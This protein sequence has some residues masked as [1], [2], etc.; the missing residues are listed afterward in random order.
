MSG[1]GGSSSDGGG[2]G[3]QHASAKAAMTG[4]AAYSGSTKP[5]GPPGG[6]ATS[7]GSGRD[8]APSG[9][10]NTGGDYDDNVRDTY[11]PTT[12]IESIHGE[13]DDPGSAS[14]D[15][16]YNVSAQEAAT[17]KAAFGS[18][19]YAGE[20]KWNPETQKVE[21]F[22]DYTFKE[23]WDRRPDAIKYSP[24]LS[25]LYAGGKNAA[26]FAK[27]KGFGF[28]GGSTSG[29]NNNTGGGG[30]GERARMNAVA[31]H[32]PYIVSGT[33]MPT[34][35]PAQ[36]WYQ[37]LGASSTNPSGFNLATEYAAAKLKVNNILSNSTPVGQLAVNET[38]YFNFLKKHN[39]NKGIL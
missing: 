27:Y 37:S 9:S 23:H 22:Q 31:P 36:K 38:P 28:T 21:R 1:G 35:S 2:G 24:T 16:T 13:H 10:P 26:E 6:G 11:S 8:F 12:N 34:D 29:G 20:S 33:T 15:P 7:R 17:K 14:Y 3:N 25:L 32:A 39:L 5:S 4:N 30:D 18:G 19:D